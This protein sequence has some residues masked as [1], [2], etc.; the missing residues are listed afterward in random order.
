MVGLVEELRQPR[1]VLPL[2]TPADV[3]HHRR[4]RSR[5]PKLWDKRLSVKPAKPWTTLTEA[6]GTGQ[7][8]WP[9]SSATGPPCWTP[10]ELHLDS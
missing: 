7:P 8:R 1:P 3:A 9:G 5:I 2:A 6:S 4:T 10:S